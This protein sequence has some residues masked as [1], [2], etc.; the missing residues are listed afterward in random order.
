[1]C[2]RGSGRRRKP[3]IPMMTRR[4]RGGSGASREERKPNSPFLAPPGKDLSQFLRRNNFQLRIRAVLRL[5]VGAPAAELRGVAEAVSLHMVIRNFNYQF[6]TQRFPGK[7]FALTPSALATRHALD[8]FFRHV[9]CPMLPRVSLESIL[10][11]RI[12]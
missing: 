7:I 11:I 1:M 3:R 2:R 5:L 8:S 9:L 6:R 4:A 10:T 12:K